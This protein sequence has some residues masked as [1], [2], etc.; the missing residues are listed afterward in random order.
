MVSS[1][2]L[3]LTWS[4]SCMPVTKVQDTL[5]LVNSNIQRFPSRMWIKGSA[6]SL[7][8]TMTYG[9]KR[10]FLHQQIKN[11]NSESKKLRPTKSLK[12]MRF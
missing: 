3:L 11:M 2:P 10:R 7:K 9:T 8:K 1:V 5:A 12:K 6:C 4:T